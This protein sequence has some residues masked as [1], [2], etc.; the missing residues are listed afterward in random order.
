MGCRGE[1]SS[2]SQDGITDHMRNTGQAMV[3]TG[4]FTFDKVVSSGDLSG[5]LGYQG[6]HHM[7]V[8]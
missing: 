5:P 8:I 1:G 7:D 4:R 3:M 6:I 2:W